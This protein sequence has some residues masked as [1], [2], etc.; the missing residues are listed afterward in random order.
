MDL[1]TQEGQ[2]EFNSLPMISQLGTR[3]RVEP[4][5]V[6]YQHVYCSGKVLN[7]Y[8]VGLDLNNQEDLGSLILAR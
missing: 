5:N 6:D 8:R 3:S 4:S 1:N 7:P 2:R